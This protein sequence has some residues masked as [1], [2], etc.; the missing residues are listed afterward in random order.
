MLP[1]CSEILAY[2]NLK[3]HTF[4]KA[5]KLSIWSVLIIKSVPIAGVV[6]VTFENI[7]QILLCKVKCCFC[8]P[9][10][11]MLLQCGQQCKHLESAFSELFSF[12]FSLFF[13]ILEWDACAPW[14]SR[15]PWQPQ[16]SVS[17]G[18]CS[19]PTSAWPWERAGHWVRGCEPDCLL[20]LALQEHREQ[21]CVHGSGKHCCAHRLYFQELGSAV[22]KQHLRIYSHMKIIFILTGFYIT[23]LDVVKKDSTSWMKDTI[24]CNL[25]ND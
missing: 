17:K 16:S 24:F 15:S 18:T 13:P 10:I 8:K 4:S 7:T 19:S 14:A 1:Q 3:P 23:L 9:N 6:Y 5:I 12:F 22:K 2:R 11:L 25:Y 20:G 21:E